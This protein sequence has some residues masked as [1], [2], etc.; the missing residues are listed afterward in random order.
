MAVARMKKVA[1]VGHQDFR[2]DVVRVLQELGSVQIVD[3]KDRLGGL[4]VA[5][6]V[7]RRP[8]GD[9]GA[10][11]DVAK[12]DE[13]FAQ[14][15]YCLRYLQGFENAQKGL[16]ESFLAQKTPVSEERFRKVV[17][18][19]DLKALYEACQA[20]EAWLSEIRNT[21]A[22]LLSQKDLLSGWESLDLAVEELREGETV[23]VGAASCPA[24]E[25]E[26]FAEEAEGRP[27]HLVKVGE[28]GGNV[29]FVF[30]ALAGEVNLA[31][32]FAEYGISR[33]SFGDLRG[34]PADILT[35]VEAKLA[36]L[37]ACENE[38]KERAR[39]HLSRKLDLMI[40]HDYFAELRGRREVV[41][42]FAETES[43]FLLQGWVKEKDLDKVRRAVE[44]CSNAIEVFADDPG[45]DDDVPVVLENHPLIEP[46][47]VVTNIY[48]RPKYGEADPTPLLAPFFFVF[49]GLALSD[50][51]YGILLALASWYMM[52]KYRI[53]RSGRKLFMLMTYGGISTTVFGAMAGGWFGDLVNMLPEQFAGLRAFRDSLLVLDP[54]NEPLKFMGVALALGV[55]QVWLG[56]FVKMMATIRS[57]AVLDALMD[58]GT[59]LFFLPSLIF[60]GITKAGVFPHLSGIATNMALAGAAAIVITQGRATRNILLKPFSGLYALYGTIGYFSDVLSYSRLLALGLATGVIGSVI[61]QIGALVRTVPVI[62]VVLMAAVFAGG[63][64]FNLAI[65]VL[66]AFIHS[67]RLQF[68][69]FFTKF[70]EGGGRAFTPFRKEGKYV[71]LGSD[72]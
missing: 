25:F 37:D 11:A 59:W 4:D 36:E 6:H 10:A 60:M 33:V 22:K 55:V 24:G 67:G 14:A 63:H 44:G 53:P 47:E 39:G 66:G 23:S 5:Q 40:L 57:G 45:P 7:G 69:E 34:K 19:F 18:E 1:I 30:F 46:F 38:I 68:V 2:D 21:R 61:N 54:M 48:G 65:N 32:E 35:E 20:D 72:R 41:E 29:N 26:A 12:A 27:V 49:F 13:G 31:S 64:L 8:V 70:F 50:A 51:A 42:R 3:L 52:K 58:Q 56:I 15:S 28:N 62:G 43:A 9:S 17:E 16:I 71:S